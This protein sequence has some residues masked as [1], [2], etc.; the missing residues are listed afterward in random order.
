MGIAVYPE[1][2]VHNLLNMLEL[3]TNGIVLDPFAGSGTTL[4]IVQDMNDA[5][6]DD[7]NLSAIMIEHNTKYVEI[8][9]ER[10]FLS[11][12]DI[13]Q[14]N[15]INYDFDI[16]ENKEFHNKANIQMLN[17]DEYNKNGFLKIFDNKKEYYDFLSLLVQGDIR[18]YINKSAV[19][20]IGSKN[21]DIDLIYNT[22]LLSGW[23]IT[24][25]TD[26]LSPGPFVS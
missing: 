12:K 17:D 15:S 23:K 25:L 1:K 5:L 19:C 21:F 14:Y 2:L 11:D 9:K 8:I 4:K 24:E 13:I 6:L 26:P 18:K 3:P 10:C 22:S 20:F 7:K 16:L